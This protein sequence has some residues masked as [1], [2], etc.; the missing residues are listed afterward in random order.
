MGMK[1][2]TEILVDYLFLLKPMAKLPLYLIKPGVT[3]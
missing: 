3:Y 2:W 1:D